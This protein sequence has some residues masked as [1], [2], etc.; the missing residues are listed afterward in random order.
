MLIKIVIVWTILALITL[1]LWYGL[2]KPNSDQDDL[3]G[4]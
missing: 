3:D 2:C 1:V 4:L